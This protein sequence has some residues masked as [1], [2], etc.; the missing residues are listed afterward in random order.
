MVTIFSNIFSKEPYYIEMHEALDRIRLGKSKVAVEGIRNEINDDK[1]VNLKKNLPCILFS[2]KFSSREDSSLLEH[3]G[4]V[5]LDFDHVDPETTKAE[6]KGKNYIYACWTSPGGEGVKALVKIAD[7]K[8]HRDHL[9]AIYSDLPNA[10]SANINEARVCFESYDPEI[11]INEDSAVYSKVLAPVTYTETEK[12][13]NTNK[14]FLNL[15]KWIINKGNTFQ[16]GERNLFIF[17]LA[18]ACCRFGIDE[19]ECISL[20]SREYL[21]KDSDF[22]HKEAEASIKSAY[23]ANASL[24]GSAVFENERAVDSFTKTEIDPAIFDVTEKPKDVIYGMDVIED[25]LTIFN[26]GYKTAETTHIPMLDEHF[27]WKRRELTILSGIGNYGKSS[28]MMHLHLIKAVKDGSKWA[29][30]SPETNPPE[31]FYHDLVEQLLGCD[32]TPKN[33]L[34]PTQEKYLEAYKFVTEHFF[35]IYPKDNAP[36]PEYIKERFLELVIKEK[37]DG[38]VVDPFN[39]LSNDYTAVKGREDK[40]LEVVLGEFLKFAQLNNVFF[41]VIAHPKT[42][43]K[44]KDGSYPCPD[45]FDLSGGAMWNNK[46]D[47][48]LV[49]HRPN[50]HLDPNDTTCEFHSK[51]IRRQKIVGVKGTIAFDFIRTKRRFY[52]NGSSPL[53]DEKQVNLRSFSEPL[54]E[55]QDE[56]VFPV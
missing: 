39:N 47:N 14:V 33:K 12:V 15:Q 21:S 44:E 51:K 25:A 10:D 43:H 22:G 1:K 3:S 45:I 56:S 5:I 9:K 53:E 49:Y 52:F 29:Y 2:G 18:C 32:C 42:M 19:Q 28:F 8:K 40:Y 50:H 6:L 11:Y 46:A 37:V 16:K 30:F 41:I 26:E 31:E 4:Y 48:V 27:K 35:Y 36:T 24:F 23:K 13:T 20:I 34:R 7:P 55:Q 17:K 54:K 38:V